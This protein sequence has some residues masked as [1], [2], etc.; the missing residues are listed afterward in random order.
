ME[1]DEGTG[2]RDDVGVDDRE[3]GLGRSGGMGI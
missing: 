1:D 3:R 2:G